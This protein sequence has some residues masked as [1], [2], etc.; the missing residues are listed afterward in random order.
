MLAAGCA[1]RRPHVPRA[2]VDQMIQEGNERGLALVNPFAIDDKIKSEVAA[3][4]G[5]SGTPVKRIRR[6]I[7]YLNDRGYINFKYKS[8]MSLTAIEAY[9]ARKGDCLSYTNLFL[10]IA[11]YLRVPVYFIHVSEARAYYEKDGMFFVSSHMAVGYG[12]GIVGS[13]Q[14]PYTVVVDF[15]REV[16]NWRLWIYESVDDESAFALFYNNV[17]VDHMMTGDLSYAGKLLSFLLEKQPQVRELYNNLAVLRMREGRYDQAL[18]LLQKGIAM[19]PSFQSL[20]T[21]AV[22]AARG[23]DKPELAKEYQEVGRKVAQHDPFFLFNQ[24][25]TDYNQGAF[26]SAIE[27]FHK[28]LRL[29]PHNP[30]IYAWLARV[31]LAAG[32]SAK[33]VK[34]YEKALDLA[35]NHKMLD[36]L[37]DEYPVL[38]TTNPS[39]SAPSDSDTSGAK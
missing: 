3:E 13:D 18:V 10:G 32:D 26:D 24:G 33:G 20:Y 19:F 21:N 4:V 16:S 7:R 25:V 6:L 22:L 17:A 15:T 1:Y 27:Q 36:T 11:R 31:Y 9:H 8:N 29:Q 5:F 2:T 14:S 23:D 35:P 38:A 37:R 28:A 34:A 12:G 30:F 39:S